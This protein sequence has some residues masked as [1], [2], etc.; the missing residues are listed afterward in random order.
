MKTAAI[1]AEY[2]PFHYGHKYL[3]DQ[4]RAAGA[5]HVA[6]I[7]SGSFT[8]RGGVAIYDKF[9]RTETALKNGVDL[10]IELPARYSL[11]SAA[12]FARGA[13]EIASALGCADMLAFG[14]ESGDIAALK[15]ASGAIEYTV[16]SAEFNELLRRGNSY[17]AALQKALLKFYTDDVAELIAS[18]NNT[19]AI[20][21]LNALDN[22]GSTIEPFTVRR[23]GAAHD[24]DSDAENENVQF[25]SGS[26]IRKMIAAGKDCS[27]Y[28]PKIDAPTSDISRLERAIL[29]NLR[30]LRRDDLERIADCAGGL[31][32]RLYKAVR[33]GTSLSGIYFM[34]K[35]K[36]YTLARIR[37]AVLC[38]FLGID[39]EI[40]REKCAYIRVLGMNSRGKEILSAANCPLPIDT[41]L[42]A[43]SKTSH[44][45][46]RQADFEA[47]L[48][49]I[50]SLCFAEPLPCGVDFTAKPVI[51]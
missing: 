37:R 7:M 32:D 29:A 38:G 34:A 17:P 21:Y 6:A 15:E 46:R 26:A 51:L 19:L 49:D 41:S 43:L 25:L 33:K 35:T 24:S 13:V 1:I 40:S 14:S 20:E 5:T 50:Y 8:Q 11:T 2:D 18:P 22:L 10:V 47:R 16:H 48:T 45:A 23:F 12:G 3:I 9:T 28:A 31:G 44:E 30:T 4:T 39:K 42:R 36:R 27:Q